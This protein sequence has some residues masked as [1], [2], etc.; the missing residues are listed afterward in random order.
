MILQFVKLRTNFPEEELLRRAREREPEFKS[1]PALL[2]KYY[3]KIGQSGH[4]GIHI[5]IPR[6][7]KILSGV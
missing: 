7:A 5:G 3:V 1:L 2:K 4:G 6:I